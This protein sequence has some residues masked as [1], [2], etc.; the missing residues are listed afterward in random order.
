MRNTGIGEAEVTIREVG[1]RDGLQGERPLPTGERASLVLGLARAG[2]RRI[3][4]ASFVSEKAVPAMAGGGDVIR[5]AK[6]GFAAGEAPRARLTGLVPNLR[7]ATAAIEAGC[8]ELSVTVAASATY[9]EK[10]VR[11]TIEESVSEIAAICRQAADA[12]LPVDAVVSCAFGSPY[13][14]EEIA[15]VFVAELAARL[16]GHGCQAI[17]LADTTGLANPPVLEQVVTALNSAL[18]GAD[19]GLHLH[20][21]RGTALLN[22]Y[23][24]LELGVRRFDT[25]LGGLG[26][27][28]F[29][30]GAGGNL[31]TEDFVSFLESIGMTSGIDLAGILELAARLR[32]LVGHDIASKVRANP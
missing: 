22:A 28:P 9:N 14:G 11:R 19:L 26:G 29:A 6:A 17:T 27:S 2:C 32:L 31:S 16:V 13:E 24:A 7:G 30:Q 8:D 18:P 4:A 25:A 5:A 23:V 21:T 20:E 12:A 10:N 1:P 3:E 15:P